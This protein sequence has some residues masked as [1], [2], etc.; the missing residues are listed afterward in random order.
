LV[1]RGRQSRWTDELL[2]ADKVNW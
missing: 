1:A 2:F